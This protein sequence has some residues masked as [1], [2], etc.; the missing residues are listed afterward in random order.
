MRLLLT[1]FFAIALLSSSCK[2]EKPNTDTG[3]PP[4][5]YRL[6]SINLEKEFSADPSGRTIITVYYSTLFE[7]DYKGYV[8]RVIDTDSAAAQVSGYRSSKRITTYKRNASNQVAEDVYTISYYG[9]YTDANGKVTYTYGSNNELIE[10][11]NYAGSSLI[12]TTLYKWAGNKVTSVIN[13]YNGSRHDLTYNGN[14]DVIDI[15]SWLVVNQGADTVKYVYKTDISYDNS[16]NP[17]STVY[18]LPFPYKS[19]LDAQA[20]SAHNVLRY[21]IEGGNGLIYTDILPEYNKEGYLSK[22]QGATYIYETV[23]Q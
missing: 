2:K 1:L 15:T 21:A 11:N 19:E 12:G 20:F 14:G 17:F 7:Y 5:T 16:P 6:K 23:S 8:S 22:Y 4:F 13:G 9:K 18:G 3:K 10:V